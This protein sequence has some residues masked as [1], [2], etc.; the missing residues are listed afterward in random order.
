M[1]RV[2]AFVGSARKK[3]T[4]RAVEQFLEQV[5]ALGGVETEIVRLSD[6]RISTCIGCKA[7]MDWG[8]EACPLQ[9]DRDALIEKMVAAD[10]VV[11][12]SPNY[13]FQVSGLTKVWLDRL[14]FILHRPR[15]FGKAFTSIVAQGIYGGTKI[16]DYLNF[17]GSGLG[18]ETVKGC[19]IQTL[20]PITEKQQRKTDRALAKLARRFHAQLAQPGYA[21]PSLVKLMLFR[22][23]RTSMRI[24]LDEG[25]CD[26]RYYA[27]QGW[28][29]SAYYHPARLGPLKQGAGALFDWAAAQMAKAR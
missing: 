7:C 26:Y 16:V 2:I 15:F 13:A 9:D 3:H 5:Q 25:A 22:L 18:F 29:E 12:A 14:A 1:K 10:G 11:F 6:Y 19:C 27:E 4:Y 8:E 28:F 24:E 20:E 17:V 23:S 21:T